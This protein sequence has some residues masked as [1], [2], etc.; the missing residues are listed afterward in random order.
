MIDKTCAICGLPATKRL[1]KRGMTH[2]VLYGTNYYCNFHYDVMKEM[3]SVSI[4]D[5]VLRVDKEGSIVDTHI[6]DFII[7]LNRK[8]IVTRY[9][10]EGHDLNL[11]E[12]ISDDFRKAYLAWESNVKYDSFII[13][14]A[15]RM[16]TNGSLYIHS[17]GDDERID[18]KK[19]YSIHYRYYNFKKDKSDF[20]NFM[21]EISK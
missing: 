15:N 9:S 8:G 12:S 3:N 6:K 18:R 10:C 19:G 7:A 17:Y 11:S 5:K 4:A 16:L 1:T 21:K 14:T 13:D 2:I 20:L